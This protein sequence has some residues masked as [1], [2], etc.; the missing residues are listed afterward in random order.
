VEFEH[1][2]EAMDRIRAAGIKIGRIQLSSALDVAVPGDPASARAVRD[3]LRAFA[4]ATYLH[5]VVER[6]PAEL[7]HYLDLPDAL[8]APAAREAQ[9]WRIHFHVPLFTSHFGVLGSTQSYVA[10]VLRHAL[11]TGA[12]HHLEIETYTWDVLPDGMKLDLLESIGR[13]YEWVLQTSASISPPGEARRTSDIPPGTRAERSG[14]T[15]T[16]EW[17]ERGGPG[18]ARPSRDIPPDD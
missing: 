6:R 13:E 9:H 8:E 14:A 10:D 12:T 18:E 1:P 11:H 2:R 16:R 5:Q 17:S 7:R 4:D 15:G 3:R